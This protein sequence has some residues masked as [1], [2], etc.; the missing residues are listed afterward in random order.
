MQ[1]C[2]SEVDIVG[3]QCSSLGREPVDSR[4]SKIRSWPTPTNTTGVR[5]FLGICGTV[6]IWIQDFGK[7]AKPLH[8]LTRKDVPF[9]WGP[10]QVAAF[11]QLKELICS[12]PALKPINYESEQPLI[13]SV[14]T[15]QTG[16][17]IILSQ[18]DSKGKRSAAHYG[19]IPINLASLNYG[20]SKLEL[21]G[22]FRA[23]CKFRPYIARAKKL[24]VELDCS[25]IKGMLK[26]PE[27]Q[28]TAVIN[29]WIDGI[30]RFDFEIVHVPAARHKGPD[31]LSRR[32][33]NNNS[34]SDPL[35]PNAEEWVDSM[36][37]TAQVYPKTPH[38][39]KKTS[40]PTRTIPSSPPL[41]DALFSD[42]ELKSAYAT[43]TP[44]SFPD[45]DQ[46]MIDILTYLVTGKMPVRELPPPTPREAYLPQR[47]ECVY[48]RE[49]D[50]GTKQAQ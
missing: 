35:E 25:S 22:L 10:D 13:L 30:K 33:V 29:C 4:I 24:I 19:S 3:H 17:G 36:A 5:G 47:P 15:S 32:P 21:Y 16:V 9:I 48:K 37:F 49:N 8:L 2:H 46:R 26:N 20:Q 14:D 18:E 23:L 31:A 43:A 45:S 44:P 40:F 41:N 6:R 1:L 7:I 50:R 11:E 39:H 27:M 12:T 34:D 38:P 28:C 42:H